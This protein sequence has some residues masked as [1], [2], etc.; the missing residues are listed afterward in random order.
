[1]RGWLTI[2]IAAVLVFQP[3]NASRAQAAQSAAS[4]QEA[5]SE[6]ATLKEQALKLTALDQ[7]L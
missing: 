5:E 7:N 2:L 1:M 6:N 3:V 4:P